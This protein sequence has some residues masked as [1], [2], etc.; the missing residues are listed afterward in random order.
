MFISC[1]K[2]LEHLRKCSGHLI[3]ELIFSILSSKRKLTLL[4]VR[5]FPESWG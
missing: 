4:Y 3:K 5:D 2:N 1:A